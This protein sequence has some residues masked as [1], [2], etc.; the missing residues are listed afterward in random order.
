MIHH[1]CRNRV[2]QDFKVKINRHE[3]PDDK[4]SWDVAWPEYNP[5][6][7]TSE[8]IIGKEWADPDIHDKD[9]HPSWNSLDGKIN[10]VSYVKVYQIVDGYPLNPVGRTGLKGRGI[11]GKWGP[12]HAADPVVT[13]WKRNDKGEVEKDAETGKPILQFVSIKRKDTGEW[14]LPGGMVDAGETVSQTLKREFLEEA[15]NFLD[16]SEDEKAKLKE[17]IEKKFMNG[18]EIYK[19][20]VDDPRNTDNAWMETTAIHFHDDKNEAFGNLPLHAG[21]DAV[22]VRWTNVNRDLRLYANHCTFFEKVV[23]NVGAYW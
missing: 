4:V 11:L 9:F 10:R 7:Y 14:A 1:K 23:K 13:R 6:L 18:T 3:V 16:K 5:P 12:N 19:G 2:Y 17:Q 8:S 22:G 21:D 20:Y 15:L